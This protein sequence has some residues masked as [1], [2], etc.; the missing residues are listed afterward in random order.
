MNHDFSF[1]IFLDGRYEL[2]SASSDSAIGFAL[3]GNYRNIEEVS[4]KVETSSSAETIN[5]PKKER[6]R[7]RDKV[8]GALKLRSNL[9]S[10][11]DLKEL[12]STSLDYFGSNINS[13]DKHD[14]VSKIVRDC[15]TILERNANIKTAGLYRV[16]GNKTVIEQ[17]KKKLNDKKLLKKEELL[18]NQ[19]VHCI[20]GL[21]KM[22]FRELTPSIMTS[23]I[24]DRCTSGLLIFCSFHL[25]INYFPL[26]R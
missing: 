23:E 13:V 6:E 17:L 15:I 11:K 1:F 22:F 26:L 24:F 14:S 10:S 4:K 21:L 18:Q 7:F 16:S 19:D 5:E 3:H 20:A 25:A 12:E 8:K 9:N 2:K